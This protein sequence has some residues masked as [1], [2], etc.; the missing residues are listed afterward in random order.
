SNP[1]W[2]SFQA[3]ALGKAPYQVADLLNGIVNISHLPPAVIA[4][5]MKTTLMTF[6]TALN[7]VPIEHLLP[8]WQPLV[9]PT[10]DDS[11]GA[12]QLLQ[13]TQQPQCVTALRVVSA[14]YRGGLMS[15]ELGGDFASRVALAIRTAIFGRGMKND[16]W[17]SPLSQ[18]DL[19][20]TFFRLF[21]NPAYYHQ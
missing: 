2:V 6:L 4:T 16:W 12:E 18:P 9:N 8:P 13:M 14:A 7:Q 15:A 1:E 3:A 17:L 21:G 10:N 19:T 5:P 11:T 20:Y